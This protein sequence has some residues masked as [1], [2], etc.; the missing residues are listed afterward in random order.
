MEG[1][2]QNSRVTV[3]RALRK[4]CS[5]TRR[6]TV[7]AGRTVSGASSLSVARLILASGFLSQEI[8]VPL[9]PLS[10][11][12]CQPVCRCHLSPLSLGEPHRFCWCR[13]L[14]GSAF[15]PDARSD[16]PR[17]LLVHTEVYQ[18]GAG[19]QLLVLYFLD[20]TCASSSI[21]CLLSLE[22]VVRAVTWPYLLLCA[23]WAVDARSGAV[24]SWCLSYVLSRYLFKRLKL[25]FCLSVCE[26]GMLNFP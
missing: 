3:C 9:T 19:A 10:S 12:T 20:V 23:L 22:V 5:A 18:P 13:S 4:A 15:R 6:A 14:C 1:E 24:S 8:L 16:L 26:Y 17:C 21:V 25:W 2:A 11:S 7:A